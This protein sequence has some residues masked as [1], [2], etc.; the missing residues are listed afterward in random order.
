MSHASVAPV[1]DL[2][3][4][5]KDLHKAYGGNEVLKGVEFQIAKGQVKAVLGPSGS[6]KS[7]ML[8]L[9]ALLEPSDRGDILLHGERIGVNDGGRHLPERT[10]AVQRRDIGM[11]FQKFNLFPHLSAVRNVALALTA[12]QQVKRHTALERA[13]EMLERVGLSERA[14]HFPSELSGGQ[15]QRVAIAR[16]LVLDPDVMLFDE[17]TSAL[18]PELVGEVLDVMEGLAR[19]GMTMIVVTH[20]VRFARRVADEVTLFDNGVIVEQAPPEDFFDRPQHER[21]RRFLSHVH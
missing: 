3:L 16:A 14:D 20:E 17:P 13:H 12:V 2:T 18:D 9:M 21:T 19:G 7:T 5:V 15:Q 6:G 10:L 4:Q 11:V 1:Q 8:R